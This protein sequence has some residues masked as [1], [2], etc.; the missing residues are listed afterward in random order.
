MT[1]NNKI[2]WLYAINA[3]MPSGYW[4]A[5][6]SFFLL[7]TNGMGQDLQFRF[8][9]FPFKYSPF[10]FL[11]PYIK[12]Y[13]FFYCTIYINSFSL[14]FFFFFYFSFQVSANQELCLVFIMMLQH[15][16]HIMMKVKWE[17]KNFFFLLF[18]T[19]FKAIRRR[20]DKKVHKQRWKYWTIVQ[21]EQLTIVQINYI[22]MNIKQFNF[23]IRL[24]VI[25]TTWGIQCSF[26]SLNFKQH[27]PFQSKKEKQTIGDHLCCYYSFQINCKIKICV[28][29]AMVLM[30]ITQQKYVFSS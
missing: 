20:R 26:T 3:L 14:Y 17:Q 11:L 7:P 1:N 5:L 8:L 6:I 29:I 12:N 27:E 15:Q 22:I 4:L 9:L 25:F 30:V 10:L 16:L 23:C 2:E 18:W 21:K 13:W 24:Y 19:E 28:A